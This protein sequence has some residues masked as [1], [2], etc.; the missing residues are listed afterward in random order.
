MGRRAA[1]PACCSQC[2]RASSS[3]PSLPAAAG[4]SGPRDSRGE[5]MRHTCRAV[6]RCLLPVVWSVHLGT[7]LLGLQQKTTAPRAAVLSL[8]LAMSAL[9]PCTRMYPCAGLH[10]ARLPGHP[11]FCCHTSGANRQ[12]GSLRAAPEPY[13]AGQRGQAE[14]ARAGVTQLVAANVSS[15]PDCSN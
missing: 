13:Q 5:R 4:V 10:P 11:H 12:A 9:I 6:H 3:I 15:D 8:I 1:Q 14:L 7:C 2:V